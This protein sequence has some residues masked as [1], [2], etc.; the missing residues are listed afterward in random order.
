MT[1]PP[2][3]RTRPAGSLPPLPAPLP[4]PA[5]PA[6]PSSPAASL[7]APTSRPGA[8]DATSSQFLLEGDKFFRLGEYAQALVAYG[9]AAKRSPSAVGPVYKL[10]LTHLLLNDYQHAGEAFER[11]LSIDP[12]HAGAR[13]NLELCRRRQAP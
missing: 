6:P 8:L 4:A 7:P 2:A 9:N 11:V 3:P 12:K 13:K 1:L 5:P 10:G